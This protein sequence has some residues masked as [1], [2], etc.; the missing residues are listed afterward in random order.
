MGAAFPSPRPARPRKQCTSGQFVLGQPNN[1]ANKKNKNRLHTV[2]ELY[3]L[4]AQIHPAIVSRKRKEDDQRPCSA[5]EAL[6]RQEPFINQNLAYSSIGHAD[7]IA[8]AR[9]LS[10]QGGSATWRRVSLYRCRLAIPIPRRLTKSTENRVV[11]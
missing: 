10:Y 6:T 3:P 7:A 5:A 2:A 4:F 8:A 9:F 1:S 11:A